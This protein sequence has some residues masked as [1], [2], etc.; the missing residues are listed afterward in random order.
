MVDGRARAVRELS[1]NL[2]CIRLRLS[3]KGCGLR[4]RVA[5]STAETIDTRDSMLPVQALGLI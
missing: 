5:T 1:Q 3:P 4:R 2:E